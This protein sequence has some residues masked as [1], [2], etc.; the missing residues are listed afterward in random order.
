L[1]NQVWGDHFFGDERTVDVHIR[2]VRA[3]ME[4]SGHDVLIQTVRGSGYSFSVSAR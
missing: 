1:L 4:A 2:R 3:S